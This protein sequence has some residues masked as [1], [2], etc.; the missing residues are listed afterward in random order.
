MQFAMQ[1]HEQKKAT[2]IPIIIREC[3]RTGT[4][5]SKLQALPR[6]AKPVKLWTDRDSA[7]KDVAEA[8]R[9][10]LESL[11]QSLI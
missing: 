4:P 7:W 10:H 3:D 2:V 8:L 1:Q 9:K 5:F 11:R 6:D